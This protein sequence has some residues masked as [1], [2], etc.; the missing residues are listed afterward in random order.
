MT[1]SMEIGM[2]TPPVGLNQFV[3]AGIAELPVTRVARVALPWLLVLF[4]M[5][6]LVTYVPW[7]S[8]ALPR[9]LA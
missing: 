1:M 6:V 3:T 8:L 4:A 9:W 5:L 2:V 7:V